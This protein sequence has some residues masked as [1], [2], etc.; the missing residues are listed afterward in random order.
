MLAHTLILYLFVPPWTSL[1][2]FLVTFS[3]LVTAFFLFEGGFD[4][5]FFLLIPAL[6]EATLGR[7][8]LL[9]GLDNDVSPSLWPLLSLFLPI[10]SESSRGEVPL[11]S[12]SLFE[13]SRG[14]TVS[15]LISSDGLVPGYTPSMAYSSSKNLQLFL[16]VKLLS[17]SFLYI[18]FIF[19]SSLCID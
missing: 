3:S 12:S 8:L 19:L 5:S 16:W 10:S 6:L 17:T 1:L 4:S 9:V 2:Q 18:L 11:S 7:D 14:N 15:E 13:R